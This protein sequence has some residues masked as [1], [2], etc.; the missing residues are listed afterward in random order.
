M[1]LRTAKRRGLDGIAVTD[2]GTIKGAEAVARQNDDARLAVVIGSEITTDEGGEIIGLFLN[3][4]VSSGPAASVIKAIH[5]QGGVAIAAHPGDI[6]RH[7]FREL[8]SGLDAYE[9]FNGRC[10]LPFLN[11]RAH[12]LGMSK[13]LAAVGGSDAH[14]TFEIGNVVTDVRGGLK[15]A[16][17]KGNTRVSGTIRY[18]I[19]GN[20][21]TILRRI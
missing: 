14:F 15:E 7:H 5:D 9:S 18:A 6:L 2:H 19:P 13:G 10:V 16:I 20:L 3:R 17:R 11:N 4:E 8:P 1:I 21:R 12:R